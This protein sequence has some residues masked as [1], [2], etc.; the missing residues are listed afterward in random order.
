MS[1]LSKILDS[2]SWIRKEI[3]SQLSGKLALALLIILITI[4]VYAA[5]VMPPDYTNYW[6]RGSKW[7]DNP[8]NAP[9]AWASHL[10]YTCIPQTYYDLRS[11]SPAVS[12]AAGRVVL[13]YNITYNLEVK[14]YP[15]NI[16]I[17]ANITVPQGVM[18]ARIRV[19]V[20]KPDGVRLSSIMDKYVDLTNTSQI[21][22]NLDWP[23]G[24][25]TAVMSAYRELM[26]FLKTDEIY[27]N[28]MKYVFGNLSYSENL[29]EVVVTPL[30]GRYVIITIFDFRVFNVQTE[31]LL[32]SIQ[33]SREFSL[34]VKGTCYGLMGTDSKG[35]D[36]AEGLF[37]GFP[38][39]LSIG[40]LVALASTA[41][42]VTAGLISGYYGGFIDEFIQRTVDVMGSIP[43]LPILILVAQSIAKTY[44]GEDKPIVMLAA[45]F[46]VLI[47]FS[48][49]GLAIIIRSMTLSIKSELYVEA[50]K[51][52]GASNLRII[53]KHILPQ[54]VPYIAASLVYSTP[55]A[56]L[57]EA[58]LSVLG[59][60]H[61]F[62]TWGNILA[63]ARQNGTMVQWWWIL[64]PGFL[65]AIVSL[66]FV[67]LGLALEKVVEPKLRR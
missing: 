27:I 29:K 25:V 18:N 8:V 64:P 5:L 34:L 66:T 17:K 65:I 63:D 44:A 2:W 10:G 59:I 26:R 58:G 40:L 49:G 50:A 3:L 23:E 38:I 11:F 53:S 46:A 13:T 14:E 21:E 33:R 12:E 24:I 36:L 7:V 31:T 60:K 39:A 22:L 56:I 19:D 16:R 62:P 41:I 20:I 15:Q 1:L 43:L 57:I 52:V 42:G 51:A 48:W 55:S 45:I 4:S 32:R 35:R 37:F 54:V 67:L 28:P 61:G 6:D 30:P 9:P 47:V